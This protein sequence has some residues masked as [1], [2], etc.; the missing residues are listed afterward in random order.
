MKIF[1]LTWIK[2]GLL[3]KLAVVENQF[4]AIKKNS[5]WFND[6]DYRNKEDDK[7]EWTEIEVEK[8]RI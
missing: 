6:P 1:V 4:M 2:C 8:E 5:E 7:I 3:H